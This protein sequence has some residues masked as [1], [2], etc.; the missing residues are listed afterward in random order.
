M[1]VRKWVNLDRQGSLDV[2]DLDEIAVGYRQ[3]HEKGEDPE[4]DH[5]ESSVT[6]RTSVSDYR[7]PLR[8]CP[9]LL[10]DCRRLWIH[11]GT[12]FALA[13]DAG[14]CFSSAAGVTIEPTIGTPR[15]PWRPPDGGTLGDFRDVRQLRRRDAAR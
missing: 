10:P 13:W 1:I 8:A 14:L 15:R 11:S 9:A 5:P 12:S 4:S 3:R 2:V 6:A 7:I